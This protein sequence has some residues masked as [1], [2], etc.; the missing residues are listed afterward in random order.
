LPE[1]SAPPKQGRKQAS[2]AARG[3]AGE[4][5][6]ADFLERKGYSIVA[7]N[8]RTRRGEIDIVAQKGDLLV[9]A[10]VKTLPRG[11]AQSLERVLNQ[12][13]CKRIVETAKS[14]LNLYRQYKCEQIRF[15]VLVLDMP[16]LEPVYHIENAF[17]DY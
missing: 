10:E 14:F 15:D 2:A 4:G 1:E 7:R 8:W 11:T 3:R 12:R 17:G 6:A 13:K 5:R 9:F 16:G